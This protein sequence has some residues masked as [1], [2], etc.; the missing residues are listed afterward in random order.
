MAIKKN[1]IRRQ[2]GGMSGRGG[3]QQSQQPSRDS[4]HQQSGGRGSDRGQSSM[5][6]RTQQ[7]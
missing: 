6:H 5:P 3:R 2:Q 1:D 7:R 4:G